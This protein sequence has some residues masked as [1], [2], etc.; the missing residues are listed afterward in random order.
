M[1]AVTQVKGPL[2]KWF[3]SK[4][5]ASK[6]YPCPLNGPII[7]PFAGGAGYSLRHAAHPVYLAESDPNILDLWQWLINCKPSDILS[8]PINNI[9]GSSILDMELS[10]GQSLLLKNWQR[11]NNVSECWTVSAWG[12]KPGQW[13]SNCRDRVARDVCFISHWNAETKDGFSLMESNMAN[14]KSITWLID[15]PYFY[16]YRY[17]NGGQF[18]YERLAA[19]VGDLKGQV[20]A[21]EAICPKTGLTPTY[22]PFSFWANTVTSRRAKN[23]NTHSKELLYHRAPV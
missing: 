14:D 5:M 3:G 2:F 19:A 18:D 21:C 4:W 17:K 8:I 6:R 1:I 16:N 15:P 22:L 9:E 10:R 12:N 23:C 11:T 20:I 7:E 13:T